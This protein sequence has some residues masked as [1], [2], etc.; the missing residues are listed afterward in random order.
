MKFRLIYLYLLLFL[1]FDFV[2]VPTFCS[3][4]LS[5][6]S[7]L[8]LLFCC[9]IYGRIISDYSTLEEYGRLVASFVRNKIGFTR[10]FKFLNAFSYCGSRLLRKGASKTIL[11]FKFV[12]C[13]E[14]EDVEEIYFE[15]GDD[16]RVLRWS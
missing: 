15:K 4:I 1:F 5:N 7:R 2:T 10:G 6:C 9:E 8:F 3:W 12:L 13:Y 11:D 14:F 16:Y